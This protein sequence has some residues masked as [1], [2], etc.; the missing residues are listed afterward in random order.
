[1]IDLNAN[2]MKSTSSAAGL[3]SWVINMVA[4]HQGEKF[5]RSMKQA[6]EAAVGLLTEAQ[7]ES[8]LLKNI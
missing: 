1:M 6:A 2:D 7:R 8:N 3:G 4:Y 5:V